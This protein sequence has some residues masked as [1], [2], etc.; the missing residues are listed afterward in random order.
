MQKANRAM[1]Q[2]RV[3]HQNDVRCPARQLEDE[4]KWQKRVIHVAVYGSNARESKTEQQS[5][6]EHEVQQRK[7]CLH[8]EKRSRLQEGAVAEDE[9]VQ[10]SISDGAEGWTHS[11]R[12][13]GDHWV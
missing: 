6:L 4:T 13:V 11:D 7:C 10:D 9:F 5:T 2:T 12:Q 1:F 8:H 3:A